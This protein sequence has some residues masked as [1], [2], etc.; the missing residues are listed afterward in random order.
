MGIHYRAAYRSHIR[1][2]GNYLIKFISSDGVQWRWSLVAY[3]VSLELYIAKAIFQTTKGYCGRVATINTVF[4]RER[5]RYFLRLISYVIETACQMALS[6]LQAGMYSSLELHI[7]CV[8]KWKEWNSSVQLWSV[9]VFWSCVQVVQTN[10]H[11]FFNTWSN[12][13]QKDNR[14]K[15]L[16]KTVLCNKWW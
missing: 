11:F 12:P 2:T 16:T 9:V 14:V 5:S 10:L 1:L 13:F 7:T 4:H 15:G 8:K 6:M 3:G